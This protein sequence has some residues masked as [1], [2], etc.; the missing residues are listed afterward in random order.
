SF[1]LVL[2]SRGPQWLGQYACPIWS[3]GPT[4]T[5]APISAAALRWSRCA[6]HENCCAKATWTSG[7][8]PRVAR[9]CSRMNS[10]NLNHQGERHGEGPATRQSRSQEAEEG[11]SQGDRR[12]PEPQGSRLAAEF[13]TCKEE[14]A[15]SRRTS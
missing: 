8:A 3:A 4:N 6:S 9:C 14:V 12:G 15:T 11:K 2:R 1:L 13:R 7:S 10:T 5:G